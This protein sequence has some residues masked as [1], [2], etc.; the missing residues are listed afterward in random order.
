MN[1]TIAGGRGLLV[2]LCLPFSMYAVADTPAPGVPPGVDTSRWE[3]EYC[4][5]EEGFSGEVEAGA[6]YVSDDSYKFGEYNG[7]NEEGAFAIGNATAR[8]RDKNANYL[9]LKLRNLGLDTRSADIEG[10]R[11]GKYRLFLD[12]RE[13]AHYV[14]DTGQTPYRGNSTLQL[15]SGWVTQVPPPA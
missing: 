6:G 7:L 12:Y 5:F 14:S 9:D 2:T 8:Y 3:C 11:Q 15:P 13:L 4:V 1:M 10:G